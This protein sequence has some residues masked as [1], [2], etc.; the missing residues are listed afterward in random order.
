MKRAITVLLAGLLL[1]TSGCSNKG[2]ANKPKNQEEQKKND[3]ENKPIEDFQWS[4]KFN[5]ILNEIKFP[6]EQRGVLKDDGKYVSRNGVFEVNFKEMCESIKNKVQ[7]GEELTTIEMSYLAESV[8]Y[9]NFK[10]LG[11]YYVE[12]P[13][14]RENGYTVKEG[15]YSVLLECVKSGEYTQDK[16][17]RLFN[18]DMLAMVAQPYEYDVKTSNIEVE[19]RIYEELNFHT[20]SRY[21]LSIGRKNFVYLP[22][23]KMIVFI[24]KNADYYFLDKDLNVI[25]SAMTGIKWWEEKTVKYDDKK[26]S[27]TISYGGFDELTE[28]DKFNKALPT[29]IGY[30]SLDDLG[31]FYQ[32]PYNL[33]RVRYEQADTD[34]FIVG[35]LVYNPV[36]RYK[37]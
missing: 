1:L 34:T 4:M 23:F 17:L 28:R 18:A 2:I 20:K 8:L 13:Q 19:E 3:K 25:G 24:A 29:Q 35:S 31:S 36:F 9:N 11:T 37:K 32:E 26:G 30:R 15:S 12:V 21:D 33:C 10:N 5:N 27:I 6:N 7:N 14:R 16:L 22:E